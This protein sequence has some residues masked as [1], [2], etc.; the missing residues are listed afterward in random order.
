MCQHQPDNI[1][2]PLPAPNQGATDYSTTSIPEKKK[3]KKGTTEVTGEEFKGNQQQVLAVW[4][5]LQKV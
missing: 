5:I 1:L 2:N 4:Q 3:K